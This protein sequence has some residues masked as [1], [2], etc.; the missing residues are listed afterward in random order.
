MTSTF[1]LDVFGSL[2]NVPRAS[3]WLGNGYY[4]S[5]TASQVSSYGVDRFVG[6]LSRTNLA[7]NVSD[8]VWIPT[9]SGACVVTFSYNA[10]VPANGLDF[11]V[12]D[13][14]GIPIAGVRAA[15]AGQAR[16]TVTIPFIVPD[17]PVNLF[18]RNRGP[19]TLTAGMS[20]A[21]TWEAD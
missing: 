6:V 11:L 3:A 1:T 4:E 17:R 19:E 15:G 20:A 9:R 18:M 13:L 12:H 7:S 2:K 5:S 10:T 14:T 21:F 8:T 16:Y